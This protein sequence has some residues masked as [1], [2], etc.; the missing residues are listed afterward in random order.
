M[1]DQLKLSQTILLRIGSLGPLGYAPASG[2]VTVAVAGIPL[3][4]LARHYLP[5]LPYILA[6]AA[7]ILISVWVHQVGDRILGTK[8]SRRLVLDELA[9]FFVAMI[10][11]PLT[12]QTVLLAF[13]I[14]RAFDIA[15]V[16]PANLVERKLPGGWGVVGDDVVAG[17]YA[18]GLLHLA[19]TLVPSLLGLA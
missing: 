17:L 12:W 14:E 19:A 4:C 9:G 3:C 1:T 8:D 7:F 5:N 6:T 2:T 16:F 15:K 11:V 18:L 10:A 13:V